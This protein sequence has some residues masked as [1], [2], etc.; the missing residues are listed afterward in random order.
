[1]KNYR[2]L[3]CGFIVLTM[4][5]LI[6]TGCGKSTNTTATD[7][8]AYSHSEGIDENGF[9]KGIKASEYVEMFDYKAI[10][11]PNEVYQVTD[12][13][14]QSAI[15]ELVADY[16]AAN[17]KITNRA[18]KDGD[19]VNIDYV[20]SIDGVE[21]SGGSTSGSGAEVIIGVTKYI[22]DFLEQ[23]IGHK[24]GET[25]NIEVTFPNDY[26]ESSLQGKDAVFVT[27]I[28]HILEVNI[29]DKF[30]TTNLSEKHGWNTLAEMKS[31]VRT[32][33]KNSAIQAYV[34]EYLSTD[35]IVTSV[36][37]SL[38]T[39]QENVML[40]YYQEYADYYQME[41]D[42]FLS[43]QLGVAN[44]DALIE[45]E[46]ETNLDTATYNLV[47]Q[48]IAEDMNFTV[49]E[50]DLVNFF[51]D[52]TGSEDYTTYKNNL[53]MPYLNQIVLCQKVLDYVSDNA[54]LL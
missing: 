26:H 8:A 9:W 42:E 37:E 3:F 54:T 24:P 19:K 28:N 38:I 46:A 49:S 15:D 39:Y 36:P 52:Q 48:A 18:V 14:V 47:C 20:G 44:V 41:F 53:G 16:D 40:K 33:L 11:I 35:V 51:L 4:L 25:F 23:L 6:L 7:Y 13:D 22:D 50:E 5:C 34:M 31:A 17:E 2:M 43:T 12:K 29:D 10:S 27:T 21:F 32:D 30:V 1:M 45:A